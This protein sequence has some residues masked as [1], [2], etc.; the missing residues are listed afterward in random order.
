[1]RKIQV[2]GL[3]LVMIL[4]DSCAKLSPTS[5]T[6]GTGQDNAP[7]RIE[8]LFLG[9]KSEHH[10]SGKYAPGLATAL[11]S[12]GINLTYTE[13]PA[14][15]NTG[16]LSRY[17]GLV[18]YANHDQISPEQDQAL[19][20][21][22]E[23]GKG[24]IPIH[25]A[26]FCFR[27]SPTYVKMVGGQ[28]KSHGTGTFKTEIVDAKHPILQNFTPFETWDETYVHSELQP[29]NHLLMVRD[30]NGRKEPWTWT[31]TQGKGRVF[32]TAYGHDERT[33]N[34][35]GFKQL[36]GNGILWAVGDKA[37]KQ[38]ARYAP[39]T[40]SYSDAGPIPNYEKRNPAPRFQAPL[41]AAESQKLIQVPVGFETQ[42]FA[43]EPDVVNPI[44][45]AWDERG[46]LWVVE[47]VD[48]PNEVREEDGE[49]DDRIKI[50]EDTN[51]DG[52][53]DKFTVFADKL[54][55]PTSLVFSNGGVIISQA[56]VF[57]FL[58]DTNGDD[59]A[60]VRETIMSGWGKFDTHAGPSNLKYGLDNKI[61][62]TVGYSAYNGKEGDRNIQFGQ[63][64]YRF[65][66]N[67][68][69]LEFLAR[70]SNNT[71]GLGFNE[72][73]DV[74]IS[75]ANNT[76]SA[77][78]Y[79][80]DSFVKRM[81]VAPPVTAVAQTG[82]REGGRPAAGA[83]SAAP[84]TSGVK[85]LDG[86]YAMHTMTPN[87]RQVDVMGGFTAA[88]GHNLYT[89]RSFPKEYW[90]RIAFVCEPTGRLVHQAIL[91]PSG[92]GYIE[93]DGWNLMASND[94]WMGPVH[95]EVGPDGAVWVADWYDFIIQHN[96][97]PS[98]GFGGYQAEN[99][100]GNAYIN[101]MRDRQ[102][103]RIYRIVYTGAK[104][105]APVK[106]DAANPATLVAALQ[107]DNML[108]RTHA[109]RLLVESKNTAVLP[110]LYKLVANQS[111]DEIG[112][113]PAAVHALWTMH[114]L[115]ALDGSNAAALQVAVKALS[116][117]AA[118]VRKA[119]VQVL[120]KNQQGLDLLLQAGVLNDA[121]L[122]TRLA[123]FLALAEMPA[124]ADAGKA[125]FAASHQADNE[126][127]G[128]LAQAL[129][130]ATTRHQAGFR[131]MMGTHNH[132]AGAGMGLMSRIAESL[133]KDVRG[134]ERWNN[135]G[136]SDAPNVAGKQV[137]IRTSVFKPR[138]GQAS[139]VILAHGDQQQG[140]GLYMDQGKVHLLVKQ[141]GKASTISAPLPEAQRF[142]VVGT[143]SPNG[144]LALEID[145]KTAAEGKAAAGGFQ[146]AL[147][148]N[149]RVGFDGRNDRKFGPYKDDFNL[150]GNINNTYI[151]V[152]QPSTKVG[153]VAE[154]P[155]VTITLRV[156]KDQMQFDK[157]TFTVKAGQVV[158]LVLE[159]TDFMLHNWVLTQMGAMAKVGA[160][161]DKMVSDPKAAEKSYIPAMPEVLAAT[162]LVNPESR[163][164]IRFKAPAKTGD[165]PYVCTFPGHW[166]LMN[167]VMKVEKAA[168]STSAASK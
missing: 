74:F 168:A 75:T 117:P 42:L 102:R 47:T 11:F 110:E 65:Q 135:I 119:A 41:S 130:A 28:F 97:T 32:Y 72:D 59:K 83:E 23:S 18:I 22:V 134:L 105:S 98:P 122:R 116:H 37:T 140:Y 14:D 108:W 76:H 146:K 167:G 111:V 166:R 56:P 100:K 158:E 133:E 155:D 90:N 144:K 121:N 27:N 150:N 12:R 15:L 46:R 51:G 25:S 16:N 33:W 3:L 79:M 45:M 70:T 38:L 9:H 142:F 88:A 149:L 139:G 151:E 60:D 106:L 141:N 85:K 165:Y 62:G 128:A 159:N 127:D 57:L 66:P 148:G 162:E 58:K 129:F 114:G 8:V 48:Y 55:I 126:K 49:G 101:P 43:A 35:E 73:F 145:G 17:D 164:V 29:D 125:L 163:T 92:S 19:T 91:E 120:P 86:H 44:T 104:A 93:K 69:N 157:K 54:N 109:Q 131:A 13:D 26:S 68:K 4:A 2:I 137:T 107:H 61:W 113:N 94:E 156:V 80:P 7:R 10:N 96:P 77:Y 118:G 78:Y 123:A 82:N 160:A 39:P 95:A 52:K 84:L 21:F 24:L 152:G 112:L 154:K 143:I 63:G 99:G 87:L 132:Q 124:S 147:A 53:A 6:G 31:R 71:W 50:C 138:D 30:E 5:N 34:Q 36:V 40:L 20:A 153:Q 1:M 161:A 136:A 67:G 115:G 89:A 103:G 64:V 81:L